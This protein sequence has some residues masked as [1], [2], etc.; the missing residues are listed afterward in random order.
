MEY[1]NV[2]VK[3]IV[4]LYYDIL[5][6]CTKFFLVTSINASS[7]LRCTKNSPCIRPRLLGLPYEEIF[8]PDAEILSLAET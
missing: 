1:G 4:I 5:L 6:W 2:N 8:P 7:P 3:I